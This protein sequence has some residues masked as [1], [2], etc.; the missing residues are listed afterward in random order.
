MWPNRTW[1]RRATRVGP[2]PT[3]PAGGSSWRGKVESPESRGKSGSNLLAGN[4]VQRA[5]TNLLRHALIAC[6]F[7][8]ALNPTIP[9]EQVDSAA[10]ATCQAASLASRAVRRSERITESARLMVMTPSEIRIGRWNHALIII[11]K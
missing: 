7:A 2:G 5:M 9:D 3:G 8:F 10:P 11:L 1:P 6:A 4:R